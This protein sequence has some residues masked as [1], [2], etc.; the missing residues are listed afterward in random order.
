MRGTAPRLTVPYAGMRVLVLSDY[1]LPGYRAGGPIRTLANMVEQLGHG[2]SFRVVTR[3]RDFGASE[4]YPDVEPGRW[5][6]VGQAEV[7]YLAPQDLSLPALRRLL[8]EAPYDVLYLN[9]FFSP[10]FTS[11]PLL[12]RRL[13]LIP[14]LPVVLAPRG[15]FSPGALRLKAARKRAFIAAARA[16]GLH[17]GVLW[18]ASSEYEAADIRRWFSSRAAVHVAPD[19]PGRI[20]SGALPPR[21]PKCAGRLDAVFLS[22]ISR[23]KNLDGALRMLAGVQGEV[24]LNIY[25]PLEDA[26]YWRECQR[27][28]E[29]LPP[30]VCVEY[31]GTVPHEEVA[32][33]L[34]QHHLFLFPTLGENFGHV[35]LEAL[36]AGCP[37][38]LSDQTP[39]RGLEVAGVGWDL[40][41]AEPAAFGAVLQRCIDMTDEEHAA[42]TERAAAYGARHSEDVT[43]LEQNRAL[44]RGASGA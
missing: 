44:F 30:N 22:R 2:L 43:V 19:V 18:Q 31:R 1:Y 28:I 13:G 6:R 42:W 34:R 12:L 27:L 41:L 15:E 5:Q 25:G 36:V 29:A 7:L 37:V 10:S 26:A 3:D 38:L 11:E 14:R 23:K 33:V 32:S 4:P 16:A 35:I 24:R 8:R 40:P 9:S 21:V 20:G 17:D 39:W